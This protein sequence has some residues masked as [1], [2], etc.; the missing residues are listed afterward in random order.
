MLSSTKLE[1]HHASRADVAWISKQL[2]NEYLLRLQEAQKAGKEGEIDGF[3]HNIRVIV[4]NW[5][6]IRLFR[7]ANKR[8]N[9]GFVLYSK[10]DRSNT[11]CEILW[12]HPDHRGMGYGSSFV[13]ELHFRKL[14]LGGTVRFINSVPESVGFWR[15]L[16][17][18]ACGYMDRA[19]RMVCVLKPED[20]RVLSGY[21]EVI[22]ISRPG[23]GDAKDCF[24]EKGRD[25]PNLLAEMQKRHACKDGLGGRAIEFSSGAQLRFGRDHFIVKEFALGDLLRVLKDLKDFGY[26]CHFAAESSSFR[27]V[28]G[29]DFGEIDSDNE[30]ETTQE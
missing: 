3:Y 29:D 7:K 24:F 17:Y 9:I 12:I 6:D 10:R 8:R 27:Y 13:R 23:G 15:R 19:H 28:G 22:K 14:C 20:Y 5:E 25:G 4:E 30:S 2:T 16:G 21:V 26:A 1:E 18:S 11:N